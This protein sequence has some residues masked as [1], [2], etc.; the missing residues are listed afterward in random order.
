[1][2]KALVKMAQ[3]DRGA[4]TAGQRTPRH[5]RSHTA[6]AMREQSFFENAL[7]ERMHDEGDCDPGYRRSQQHVC[8]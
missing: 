5:L 6:T 1:M 7:Q 4:K 3:A 8:E 2:N